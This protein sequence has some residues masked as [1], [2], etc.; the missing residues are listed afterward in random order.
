MRKIFSVMLFLLTA[1]APLTP[2][3]T[4]A[5]VLPSATPELFEPVSWQDMPAGAIRASAYVPSTPPTYDTQGHLWAANNQA[6]FRLDIRTGE[7]A[8]FNPDNGFPGGS[9]I[10]GVTRFQEDIW[11]VSTTGASRY[12]KGRWEFH[13]YTLRRG[14]LRNFFVT[15]Y[16]LWV[17]TTD[18]LV[19]FDGQTWEEFRLPAEYTT[20]QQYPP[21]FISVAESSDGSYWFLSNQYG[22]RFDGQSWQ[23][24]DNLA[25]AYR[26]ANLSDGTLLFFF[27][28]VILYFDGMQ[29]KPLV[30]PGDLYQYPTQ[31]AFIAP[32]GGL[33]ILRPVLPSYAE[34]TARFNTYQFQHGE[35]VEG[36]PFEP[37][38][39]PPN[40]TPYPLALTPYGWIVNSSP[41]GFGLYNETDGYK[42]LSFKGQ[43]GIQDIVGRPV[44]GFA[45]DGA[46]WTVGPYSQPVRF[47]GRQA[48]PV[49]E[50]I[51]DVRYPYKW[52]VDPD[53]SFW[54]VASGSSDSLVHYDV[55]QEKP[56][57]H[58]LFFRVRD[59]AISPDGRLWVASD[60]GFI[61]ELT[62]AF[63]K[64]GNFADLKLIRI[65][66]GLLYHRAVPSRILAGPAG[67][68]L[69]F[70][71]G[72]GLY[73]YDGSQWEFLGLPRLK[74]ATALA[75]DSKGHVWSGECGKLMEYDGLQWITHEVPCVVPAQMMAAADD[76]IWF[77]DT[78]QG[79]VY[80]FHGGEFTRLT[81][82]E[83][84][85]FTPSS[86]L[87]APDGAM[88]FIS[89][90]KWLRYVPAKAN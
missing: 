50:L 69:V 87:Q 33:K 70:V 16:R 80:S 23:R 38:D 45:P 76:S 82:D 6:I 13:P 30:L 58:D 59:A 12:R 77:V 22:L 36:E 86:I 31:L 68:V 52:L 11:A 88:W 26:T 90:Q 32:E 57:V 39:P 41:N 74:D 34:G 27:S 47:D 78:C 64:S 2:V 3:P 17:T 72:S 43:A 1:C 81:R 49:F 67:E 84:G 54:G 14:P 71:G 83:M 15:P 40:V 4:S 62:P 65:G 48:L 28:A 5:P 35:V 89:P 18:G 79:E 60:A 24:Y 20:T 53:G 21:Y 42:E 10:L 8:E 25:G 44:I 85:G 56:S 7:L 51:P 63:L 73:A 61:T 9:E 19:H 55:H 29:I 75:V 37:K 66:E 46:L